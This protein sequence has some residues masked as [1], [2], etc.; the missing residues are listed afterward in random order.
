MGKFGE[1]P[2]IAQMFY[3]FGIL[4]TYE[5]VSNLFYRARGMCIIFSHVIGIS[6]D[7]RRRR[8]ICPA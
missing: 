3:I 7:I 4:L 5:T 6:H 2:F 8:R 1:A